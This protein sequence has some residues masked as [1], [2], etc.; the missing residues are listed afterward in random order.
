MGLFDFL[1]GRAEKSKPAQT[2]ASKSAKKPQAELDYSRELITKEIAPGISLPAAFESQWSQIKGTAI[3]TIQIKANVSENLTLA[4]SKFGH[5]PMMPAGADYPKDSQGAFMYPLAQLNFSEIPELE[6]YPRSGYLQF[7]IS[8]TD[9]AF[10]MDF[11]NPQSQVNFRVLFFEDE[12][13]KDFRSDFAFLEETLRSDMSP[14]YKPHVL[15][16]EKKTD[17]LGAADFRSSFHPAFNLTRFIAAY[18]EDVADELATAA[19]DTFG[20]N[21]HKIG[22]YA[23]FTQSDPR[24]KEEESGKYI[25]L[26]QLDTDDEIMWGDCGVANFFI[27]PDDLAKKDFSKVLFNWDCC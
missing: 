18:P 21:G 16:F 15:Q 1:F 13:V 14:V 17:Y 25:L 5:F 4:Q 19:W 10:G 6:G 12:E 24:E 26:F 2:P 8:I 11:E 20:C 22:G 3:H 9:D 27:H 7:Y 23:Y